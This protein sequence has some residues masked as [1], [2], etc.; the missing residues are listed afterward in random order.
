MSKVSRDLSKSNKITDQKGWLGRAPSNIALIK[1]MGKLSSKQNKPTNSSI[2]YTLNHLY[3]DVRITELKQNKKQNLMDQWKPLKGKDYFPTNLSEKGKE[4]FLKHFAFLKK[5]WGIK[6]RYFLIESANNFPSDCGLA[7]S[8]S[9]F[10]ALTMAS[11]KCFQDIKYNK[12]F[13]NQKEL[14]FLSRLGSGSSCRSFYPEWV[15]WKTNFGESV[16][17]PFSEL[18]HLV[19]IIEDDKKEISS[20][21][22]HRLVTESSLFV[23]RPQRANQRLREFIKYSKQRNWQNLFQICWDEFWDMHNL[24]HTSKPPFFYMNSDTIKV[25]S[26]ILKDWKEAGDGPLVTMDA[27]P[28][29]HLLFRKDQKKLF[30]KYLKTYNK[31]KLYYAK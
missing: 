6:N 2:S 18:N 22:A 15:L 8:A 16:R 5:T 24:F 31:Y 14:S 23:G 1:Y 3:T 9:S 27:G 20:S 10:A 30:Q 17:L 28:N 4:R 12:K 21:L 26:S 19:I 13:D 11:A 25:L 29:V 7:S